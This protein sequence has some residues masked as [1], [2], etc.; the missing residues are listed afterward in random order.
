M[1]AENSNRSILKTYI[2]KSKNTFTLV[3]LPSFS[4]SGVISAEKI[5][6]ET[7]E[8]FRDVCMTG[9]TMHTP[10]HTNACKFFDFQLAGYMQHY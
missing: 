9:G 6:F 10:S 8:K 2:S 4:I 1:A 3:T 5:Q 7:V